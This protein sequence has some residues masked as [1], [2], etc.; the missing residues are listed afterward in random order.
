MHLM[1]VSQNGTW[2]N[3]VPMG[4]NVVRALSSMDNIVLLHPNPPSTSVQGVSTPQTG[5]VPRA[6]NYQFMFIDLRPP[7]PM[8]PP[9]APPPQPDFL[10]GT[11]M[12]ESHGRLED[13]QTL[14]ELGRGSFAVV[15]KVVHVESGREYAMKVMEKKKLLRGMGGGGGAGRARSD[16]YAEVRDKVLSEARIL[17]TVDHPNVVRFI[18]IF[19]TDAHLHLV[20]E[21]VEGGELFDHLLEHGAFPEPDARAIST[22]I[23]AAPRSL[24][25]PSWR[26]PLRIRRGRKPARPLS[27]RL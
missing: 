14:C 7:R 22:R 21:L 15:R 12:Y 4:K 19:E 25:I 8:P 18:D 20:M 26:H 17:R 24:S 13:Y 1:D 3:N 9:P 16:A 2:W 10:R 27:P 6:V 23:H 11:S 5:V